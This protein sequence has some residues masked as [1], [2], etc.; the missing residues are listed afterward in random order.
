MMFA[1]TFDITSTQ[2]GYIRHWLILIV[3]V[4]ALMLALN[5]YLVFAYLV[6][7]AIFFMA[8]ILRLLNF[9]PGEKEP[10]ALDGLAVVFAVIFAWVAGFSANSNLRFLFILCSS[11]I[12]L[13]HCYY[14]Y[15]FIK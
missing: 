12:V 5:K 14:I 4:E 11:V 3:I 10:L 7:A 8:F 6:I 13:P 9:Y 15:K 1:N 2:W